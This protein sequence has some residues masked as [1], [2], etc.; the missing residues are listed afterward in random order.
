MPRDNFPTGTDTGLAPLV[1]GF[2]DEA[3]PAVRTGLLRAMLGPVGAV[4]LGA[5]AA[6][7]VSRLL[8]AR[9]SAA[10]ELTPEI[11][12]SIGSEQVFELARYLEQ[13]APEALAQ[14]PD[15]VGNPQVWMATVSGAL[16]LMSIKRMRRG[17]A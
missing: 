10:I 6:C 4:G 11:V 8:P 5:V 2:Y 12:R 17:Y 13:K 14:L 3:P 9:P 16:L 7:A 1:A 15:L